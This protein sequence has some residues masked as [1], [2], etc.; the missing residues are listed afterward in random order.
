MGGKLDDRAVVRPDHAKR[1]FAHCKLAGVG[2]QARRRNDDGRV[3]RQRRVVENSDVAIRHQPAILNEPHRRAPERFDAEPLHRID[4][5]LFRPRA[6]LK[7]GRGDIFDHSG[8]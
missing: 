6:Q 3:V 7:I 2:E 5:Q 8:T 4:E 1:L